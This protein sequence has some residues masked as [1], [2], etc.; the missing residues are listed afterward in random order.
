MNPTEDDLIRQAARDAVIAG[1]PFSPE[2][3]RPKLDAERVALHKNIAV[4]KDDVRVRYEWIKEARAR[5]DQMD[6]LDR[7]LDGPKPRA[8]KPKT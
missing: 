8:R 2:N 4:W 6:R 3:L 7:A 5:L 1:D